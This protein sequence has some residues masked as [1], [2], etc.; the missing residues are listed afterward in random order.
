MRAT[1]DPQGTIIAKAC[2]GH[3]PLS[4]QADRSGEAEKRLHKAARKEHFTIH[5]PGH[6]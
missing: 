1:L 5:Y 3:H 6:F 4:Q 2:G